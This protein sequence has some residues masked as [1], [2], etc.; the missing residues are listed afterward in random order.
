MTSSY[1]KGDNVDSCESKQSRQVQQIRRSMY[2]FMACNFWH[3]S[4][5]WYEFNTKLT[6]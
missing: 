1:Y 2:E 5:I 3:D 6:G 4:Q